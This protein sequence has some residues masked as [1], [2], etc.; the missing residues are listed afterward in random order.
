LNSENI[1]QECK[2]KL[3][4][5]YESLDPVDLLERIKKCQEK[6]WK[7][8]WSVEK[9]QYT[10]PKISLPA[11]TENGPGQELTEDKSANNSTIAG[12]EAPSNREYRRTRKPRKPMVARTWR[13]RSDPFE[14][15]WGDL[16]LL[17]ELNP[18]R[19]PKSL[20]DDLLQAQPEKFNLGHLRTL[21]R[22][23]ASWRAE[24]SGQQNEQHLSLVSQSS[25]TRK[26]LSSVF[27]KENSS[28]LEMTG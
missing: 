4:L 18:H 3:K 20:L 14:D 11:E 2:E 25:D 22:R 6:F 12:Q 13:T 7:H 28:Q 5:E 9:N 19:T 26:Y 27:G 16:Q 10:A 15:V 8:A 1:T 21:Q 23:V 17:L 24:N